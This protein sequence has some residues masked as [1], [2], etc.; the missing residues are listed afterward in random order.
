MTSEQTALVSVVLL[1]LTFFLGRLTATRNDGKEQGVL[2]NKVDNLGIDIKSLS[3]KMDI[4]LTD[5]QEEQKEIRDRV[6]AVEM[7]AKAANRRL[8][9]LELKHPRAEQD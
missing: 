5:I 9:E 1:F 3:D 7:S 2:I 6:V 4:K 8:D